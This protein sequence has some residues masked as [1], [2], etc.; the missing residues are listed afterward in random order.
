LLA[1]E[2]K[3]DTRDASIAYIFSFLSARSVAAD[4]GI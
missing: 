1:T 2:C 4:K 3:Q